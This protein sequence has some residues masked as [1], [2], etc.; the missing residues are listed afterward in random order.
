MSKEQAAPIKSLVIVGGGTAGW[1]A[2][3]L[4]SK[5]LK[6]THIT[7]IESDEIGTIGVGEATIPHIKTFNTLLGLDEYEVLKET[8]GTYKLGI[9]FI[10]WRKQGHKYTH[11]FGKIGRDLMWIKTHQYWLK[12]FPKG[13]FKDFDHYSINSVAMMK[14]TY[15]HLN[16]EMANSPLQDMVSAYHFDAG[17]YAKFLR[18]KAEL[19]GTTRIEG[20]IVDVTLRA[21]D[22]F[23]ESVTLENGKVVAGDLFIDCSGINALLIEKKMGVGY[24]SYADWLFCDRAIAV[25]CESI[26]TWYPFTRSTAHAAGWQWRIPLQ[27]RIGNGHVYSS[28]YMSDDEAASILLNNLDGKPRANHFFLK[29]NPG[30][31]H[32]AWVKNVVAIGLSGG[33]IEPLES[34]AIHM[35]QNTIVRLVHLF[36]DMGFDQR[37]IDEFNRRTAFEYDDI[38]DFIIAHYKVTEREDTPFWRECKHMRVPQPLQERLDLF[39][40]CGRY[41]KRAHEELFHDESWIQVLIGQGMQVETYDPNV[42]LVPEERIGEYLRDI[43]RVIENCAIH[44]PTQKDYIQQ[45]CAAT[46]MA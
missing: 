41:F 5:I 17:L 19:A 33:F 34:T 15:A 24:T 46:P 45:H 11:G 38:R 22:G 29:F 39:A 37:V 25:P 7:L 43:E 42:D 27:H 20:K 21:T 1:M 2:A 31:R 26:D 44:L 8:Q 14:N 6:N 4:Y 35:I 28:R 3:A 13:G 9:E 10:N 23:V 18:K 40:S 16:Q 36:P 32:R 12:M 30:R